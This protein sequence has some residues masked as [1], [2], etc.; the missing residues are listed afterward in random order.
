[1]SR[2]FSLWHD[3]SSRAT[4]QKIAHVATYH[5]SFFHKWYFVISHIL[6]RVSIFR[7][8]QSNLNVPEDNLLMENAHGWFLTYSD[9]LKTS[10]QKIKKLTLLRMFPLFQKE[11]SGSLCRTLCQLADERI[12]IKVG[13]DSQCMPELG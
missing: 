10:W 6:S 11:G 5:H 12:R 2:S 13:I 7:E 1:M 4:I 8:S 9:V 3:G